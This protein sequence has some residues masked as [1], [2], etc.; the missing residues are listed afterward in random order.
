VSPKIRTVLLRIFLSPQ[1]RATRRFMSEFWR[2]AR[3]RK[4]TIQVFLQ[5][6]D[7]Y[8]YLLA[9]YLLVLRDNY[10]VN[11]HVYLGQALRAEF[12]PEPAMLVEYASRDC[13]LLAAELGIPMLD[14]GTTPVVEHRR[15]L[16]DFLADEQ[17][18]LDF[19][20]VFH[21]ALAGYWRGDAE[22]IARLIGNHRS[23]GSE[24]AVLVA[25]NQL[26]LRKLG[27]YSSAM[28]LYG[29]EW[30]WGVD[31]LLYLIR[32]LD[33]LGAKRIEEPIEEFASLK[34]SMK[35]ELPAAV[36]GSATNLPPLEFFFS[37]RSPYSY[38]AIQRTFALAKAF[39]LELQI[40]PV[41]PMVMRGLPV[42][43]AKLKYIASDAARE[44]RGKRIAFGNVRDPLGAGVERCLAVFYYARTQKKEREF[45]LAATTGI[46][47]RAVDVASDEGMRQ[48]T[49]QAGLFWPEVEAAMKEE[50][51][52]SEVE[53]NRAQLTAVG[54][55]GVP[56]FLL[57]DV[58]V[59]G[60]DRDWLL[61]R[62]IE[63]LC[64]G[65]D[66]IVV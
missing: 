65:S 52:R 62:Q 4:H 37:F 48:V 60:Q 46:W 61:T 19:L 23:D 21:D 24:T 14:K 29:G 31:R 1:V 17:G 59:W 7:P 56:A 35:L 53:A 55:W 36:P 28:V 10:K 20:D 63:D 13:V 41:L 16:L 25:K 6:D 9:H 43:K 3:F 34:Q 32:R 22:A 8:S 47:S 12:M 42:P 5:L 44:A 26:L 2:L 50:A 54:L 30:Y 15:A 45:M 49:E 18:Q 66:G 39:G 57:G 38:L 11:I 33:G 40:K 51:W 27:H 64:I 58:A